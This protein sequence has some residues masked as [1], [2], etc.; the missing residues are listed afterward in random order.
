MFPAKHWSSRES[1]YSMQTAAMRKTSQGCSAAIRRPDRVHK[2]LLTFIHWC[3][4]A[5][6]C[7]L[8][9]K[10]SMS[11]ALSHQQ[12]SVFSYKH[13]DN[14]LFMQLATDDTQTLMHMHKG[15]F[16]ASIYILLLISSCLIC[17]IQIC[18]VLTDCSLLRICSEIPAE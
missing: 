9:K 18:G 8:Q 16:S 15:L 11:D 2:Y 3:A 5:C 4:H 1:E 6:V 17:I 12:M 14:Y 7:Q 13:R 10:K